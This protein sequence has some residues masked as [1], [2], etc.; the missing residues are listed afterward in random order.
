MAFD[1]LRELTDRSDE[2]LN[3]I[4]VLPGQP[5]PSKYRSEGAIDALTVA[6]FAGGWRNHVQAN[7]LEAY[8]CAIPAS[9]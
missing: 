8:P 3:L 6:D 4:L 7:R 5:D 2:P 9:A 1:N